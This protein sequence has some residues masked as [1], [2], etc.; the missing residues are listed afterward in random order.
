MVLVLESERELGGFAFPAKQPS[1]KEEKLD[2]ELE[3]RG[4]LIDG[5]IQNTW[6]LL[7]PWPSGQDTFDIDFEEQVLKEKKE[8]RTL[9]FAN[10]ALAI[11]ALGINVEELTE[12]EKTVQ[13]TSSRI[14]LCPER[15]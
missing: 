3:N 14:Q 10:P 7:H 5:E 6:L 11:D 15:T 4:R 12:I 2:F 9:F 1:E 8:L 13:F